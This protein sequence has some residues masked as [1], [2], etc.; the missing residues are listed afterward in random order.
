M[1]VVINAVSKRIGDPFKDKT[2][3]H[4]IGPDYVFNGSFTGGFSF[5]K[6]SGTITFGS[7]TY[8]LSKA[9][10]ADSYFGLAKQGSVSIVHR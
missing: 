5:G 3:T 9:S 8:D 2:M 4:E 10:Y 1:T 6:A 7:T